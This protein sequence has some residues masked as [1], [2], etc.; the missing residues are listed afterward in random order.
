MGGIWVADTEADERFP[1]YCR[2][3]VG[4]VFPHVI[5]ALTATLIGD[6]VRR[7]QTQLFVDLG[8]LRPHEATGPTVSTGV[9][10]GYLYMNASTMRLFGVRMPGMNPG[11]AEE[12]VTGSVGV[13]PPYQRQKGD[14]NLAATHRRVAA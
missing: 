11:M 3:N 12:Q 2:G 14:R 8:V 4:E 7:H 5:T 9:F 6:S 13:L 1:L 10:G